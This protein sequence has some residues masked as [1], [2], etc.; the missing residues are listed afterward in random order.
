MDNGAI[1][2]FLGFQIKHDSKAKTLSINQH[3]YVE[4]LAENFRLTNAKP[5]HMPMDPNVH[6]SIEQCPSMPNQSAWMQGV[7]Y[8][9]A[10]GSVLWPAVVSRPDIAF[11]IG[12]LSQFVQNPGSVHWK[13]LGQLRMT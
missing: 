3:A 6:F 10:I 7:P 4:S 2:W 11:A 12:I 1:S 5:V 13:V 9:E 8:I